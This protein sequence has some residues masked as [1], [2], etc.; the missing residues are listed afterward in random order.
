VGGL[1]GVC[2]LSGSGV[3]G[4]HGP[5]S[6]AIGC[7]KSFKR[8]DRKSVPRISKCRVSLLDSLGLLKLASFALFSGGYDPLPW[9]L[10]EASEM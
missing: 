1:M 2:G 6:C 9:R 8:R 5:V 10:E 3:L 7:W 4:S